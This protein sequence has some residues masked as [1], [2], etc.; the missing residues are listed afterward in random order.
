ME[1]NKEQQIILYFKRYMMNENTQLCQY[2]HLENQKQTLYP[3]MSFVSNRVSRQ[4]EY[5]VVSLAF[6]NR[7]TLV[8][9]DIL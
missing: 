1:K 5:W 4:I 8:I 6:L 2:F 9:N 7:G 3:P